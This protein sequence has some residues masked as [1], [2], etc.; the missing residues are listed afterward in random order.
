MM[1]P[2]GTR[3]ATRRKGDNKMILRF[4]ASLVFAA[5]GRRSS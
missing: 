2:A 4:M 3:T 1:E 5:A